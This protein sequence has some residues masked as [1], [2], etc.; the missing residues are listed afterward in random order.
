MTHFVREESA[1]RRRDSLPV[2]AQGAYQ[3]GLLRVGSLALRSPRGCG[4]R[5]RRWASATAGRHAAGRP[6]CTACQYAQMAAKMAVDMSRCAALLIG[7]GRTAPSIETET[8]AAL[9]T[10]SVAW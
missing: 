4:R 10:G 5:C 6:V 3:L 1:A 8:R 7:E 2:P 9:E